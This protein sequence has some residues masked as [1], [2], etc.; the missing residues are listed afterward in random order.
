M[1][2]EKHSLDFIPE[3]E[4]HGSVRNLFSIWFSANMQITVVITGA[5][6][7]T[8]GLN[9][10]WSLVAVVLGNLIGGLFMATHSAQGP[11]LGIPQMIQSR[12]QFGVIGAVLPLILVVIMYVGSFFA[13]GILGAQAVHSVFPGISITWALIILGAITLI[14]T[15]FGYDLI[16]AMEKYLAI[17]FAIVFIIVT[18]YVVR[19][20]LPAHSWSIKDFHLSK[21]ILVLSVTATW[22][23]TYAPYVADYS[24]YLPKNTSS[25]ATFGYTYAGGVIGTMWMMIL[26]VFLTAAIPHFTDNPSQHLAGLFGPTFATILYLVIIIGVISINVLNLYCA[27]MATITTTEAFKKSQVTPK[28]R[29]NLILIIAAIGTVLAIFGQSNL[30]SIFSDFMLFLQYFMIPWSA[31]NLVDFYFLRHG[32]Y[33]IKDIFDINGKYGK[34]NWISIIAYLVT[35]VLEIPFMNTSVYEGPISKALNGADIAW[36]VGLVIPA[37]LYYFP[38]RKKFFKENLQPL[39]RK[40]KSE[41]KSSPVHPHTL[42][43]GNEEKRI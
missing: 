34:F 16:H 11:K 12:A 19:M 41:V 37:I 1:K 8:Y 18:I 17:V 23:L 15:V 40:V 9:I 7:I 5:L 39:T 13:T 29:F 6:A 14:I 33:D 21:F 36:A 31:I 3:E 25:K 22:L 27:F 2:I 4:R 28:K 38:M 32:E 24:R 42:K 26:G 35:I 20:P 30:M 43:T 10:F